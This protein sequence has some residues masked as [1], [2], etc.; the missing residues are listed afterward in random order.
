MDLGESPEETQKKGEMMV[1]QTE[2]GR[3]ILEW[4]WGWGG[5]GDS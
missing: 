5:D 3:D 1:E 2:P 4:W